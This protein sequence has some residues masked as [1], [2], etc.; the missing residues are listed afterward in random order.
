MLPLSLALGSCPLA[1]PPSLVWLRA[2]RSSAR[3]TSLACI[4]CFSRCSD[5][6]SLTLVPGYVAAAHH[7]SS[8]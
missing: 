3:A 5:S 6:A 2:L 7:K 8:P 1:G 4:P